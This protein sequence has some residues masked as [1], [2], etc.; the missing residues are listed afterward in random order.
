MIRLLKNKK[1]TYKE[2]I[3][4]IRHGLE[5][6][7]SH[8]DKTIS[9][10][11][12]TL[13]KKLDDYHLVTSLDSIFTLTKYNSRYPIGKQRR[14]SGR[15]ALVPQIDLSKY[16]LSPKIEEIRVSL[17]D[18]RPE[19]LE[20]LREI[21]IKEGIDAEIC[22]P[23]KAGGQTRPQQLK[24]VP[25]SKNPAEKIHSAL[26]Y[27]S[28]N[29]NEIKIDELKLSIEFKAKRPTDLRYVRIVEI[30]WRHFMPPEELWNAP[31]L[32][33]R[34]IW[35]TYAS[36]PS[37]KS[38]DRVN[39]LFAPMTASDYQEYTPTFRGVELEPDPIRDAALKP[40]K[41]KR[42]G[43]YTAIHW[44]SQRSSM[45]YEI[46]FKYKDKNGVSLKKED[47]RAVLSLTAAGLGLSPKGYLCLDEIP[48]FVRSLKKGHLKF[49]LATI[50]YAN[51]Q[52][53]MWKRH[54]KYFVKA[55]VF[56]AALKDWAEAAR[57]KAFNRL[58]NRASRL[59]VERL[60]SRIGAH[61]T[62]YDDLSDKVSDALIRLADKWETST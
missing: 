62:V 25:P 50:P 41:M 37:D 36:S 44:G 11:P 1:I 19:R 26:I 45:H 6:N 23:R 5:F 16:R 53:L 39:L 55:G 34:S 49:Y 61:L 4:A 7:I 43:A 8:S 9:L 14:F 54:A 52:P 28:L 18:M 33:P 20:R 21:L 56:G 59:K 17:S 29:L 31:G 48:A 22:A 58:V 10:H 32:R 57:I 27:A 46:F 42:P 15:A 51:T 40:Q 3:K 13:S 35:R 38:A 47:R 12:A 2:K 30:L 60:P 24:I